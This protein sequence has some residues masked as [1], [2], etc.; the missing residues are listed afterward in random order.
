M[1]A[2]DLIIGVIKHNKPEAEV[3]FCEFGGKVFAI[4]SIYLTFKETSRGP[5]NE[6]LLVSKPKTE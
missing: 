3:E 1:K 5:V 4:H 2:K 6:I